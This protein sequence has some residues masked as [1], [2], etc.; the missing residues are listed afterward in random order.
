MGEQVICAVK[1]VHKLVLL[2]KRE[3]VLK[4]MIDRLI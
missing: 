4:S 2:A 1:Y 3:T